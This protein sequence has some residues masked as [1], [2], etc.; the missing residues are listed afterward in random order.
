[1]DWDSLLDCQGAQSQKEGPEDQG[2]LL[3]AWV[4]VPPQLA[5][6]SFPGPPG[7]PSGSGLP[8]S[9]NMPNARPQHKGILIGWEV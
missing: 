3:T 9:F 6:L 8:V 2:G 4:G 1:M 7:V 5:L